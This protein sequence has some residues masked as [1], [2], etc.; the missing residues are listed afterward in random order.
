MRGAWLCD[1]CEGSV[2]SVDLSLSCRRCGVPKTGNRCGCA[3]LHHSISM[4]RSAF[5][6]DG[7]VATSVKRLKYDGEPGRAEHLGAM[8]LP[9]LSHFGALDGLVP[10]PLHPSKER[11]R[12]FNQSRLLA[13]EVSG[14]T[15]IPVMPLLRRTVATVSQTTLSGDDRRKNVA[16]AFS[17]DPAWQPRPGGRLLL[18]DDVRT[19][20]ST[21]SACAVA[22]GDVRPAMIGVATFAL[23]MHRDRIEVLRRLGPSA[24][25]ASTS[26]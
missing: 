14:L 5:V 7:W 13:D 17:V 21:L 19:T 8:L 24:P 6:Y 4:A 10:V 2:P 25:T 16:G 11:A 12:G 23:D 1:Q 22:L 18:I 9:L 26:P 3:E 20:G 15:G